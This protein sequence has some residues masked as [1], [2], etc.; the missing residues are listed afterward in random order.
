MKT[1]N[2]RAFEG[3]PFTPEVEEMF[4]VDNPEIFNLKEGDP[5]FLKFGTISMSE[6]LQNQDQNRNLLP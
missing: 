4:F 6:D 3:K 2:F 5:I 1:L